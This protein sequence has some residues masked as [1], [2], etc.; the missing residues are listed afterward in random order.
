MIGVGLSVWPSA[1]G[2][3]GASSGPETDANLTTIHADGWQGSYTSPPTFD[4]V[5]DPRYAVAERPGFNASGAGVTVVDALLLMARVRQPYPNHASLSANDVALQDFIYSGDTVTGVTNNSTRAYPKP[6][7]MWL[8]HDRQRVT[9]QS[10]T[11]RLAVAHWHA[12][13]GRP[14]AAVKFIATDGTTTVEQTVSTMTKTD[15]AASGLSVPHFEATLDFSTLDD[16]A[17]ITIDAVIYPWVGPSTQASV[18][19][20]TYPSVN[21]CE[22]KVFNAVS[23]T[24]IY[25][26]VDG[27]GA[28]T[29]QASTTE[30]TALANPYATIA[31][32]AAGI[33]T[34][35]GTDASRGVVKIAA[36][37]TITHSSFSSVVVGDT[38]LIVEGLTKATSILQDAGSSTAN[39]VPDMIKFK[40]M[41]LKRN[42]GGDVIFL[43]NAAGSGS[44]NMM[45]FE[46][47]DFDDNG[48]G[49][50]WAAWIYRT[51]RCWFIGTKSDFPSPVTTFSVRNKM[52]ILIG[53][54][55]EVG[56]SYH[57]AGT[58]SL[59]ATLI[60]TAI[61]PGNSGDKEA[62]SNRFIGFNFLSAN[63]V[64]ASVFATTG[65]VDGLGLVGN[66]FEDQDG[67]TAATLSLGSNGAETIANLVMQSNTVIGQRANITYNDVSPFG[68]KTAGLRF[69]SIHDLNTKSDVFATDAAAIN[70]WTNIHKVGW[71]SNAYVYGDAQNDAYGPGEWVG[72]FGAIG[73]MV[74]TD[75]TPIVTDWSD[76]QSGTGGGAGDGDYSPGAST[77]LPNIPA[78]LTPYPYDLNGAPVPGDGTA[79]V[80]AAQ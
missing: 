1:V 70:N 48:S 42:A 29:P 62:V 2:P 24:T 73:D 57:I 34:L 72:E 44:S 79:Y 32:A 18:D 41:T 39:S 50:P 23:E 49:D 65:Q 4:P 46:D 54:S 13:S 33:Q 47:C 25:A 14:V 60:D 5:G 10:Y 63:S 80:G 17:L 31:V 12:R 26:Y 20:A 64:G 43:E 3:D 55:G 61:S 37:T 19:Y 6:L 51:G 75:A 53:H 7:A 11:A 27:V 56:N 67:S 8:D 78:G 71:H 21:F 22:M 35:D 30:A 77:A 74:G 76:D 15:Y 16:D 68:S 38:P 40:N 58:K 66:V 45:I 52:A 69:N 36:N 9:A 28:G 59:N